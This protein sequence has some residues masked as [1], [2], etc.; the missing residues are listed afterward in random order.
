MAALHPVAWPELDK[1]V[2]R[3]HPLTADSIEAA[4]FDAS[5][6]RQLDWTPAGPSRSANPSDPDRSV[7][8]GPNAMTWLQADPKR[9]V[10]QTPTSL[11]EDRP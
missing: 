9:C 11:V 5:G 1:L 6:M 8:V 7:W 2:R 3:A 10:K 4:S